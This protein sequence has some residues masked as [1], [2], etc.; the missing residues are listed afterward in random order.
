M[1][2][3]IFQSVTLTYSFNC[4]QALQPIVDKV[5]ELTEKDSP[6]DVT[7]LYLGTPSF[8]AREP[9]LTQTACFRKAGCNVVKLDLSTSDLSS[10]TKQCDD[11]DTNEVENLFDSADALLVSGG[12]TRYALERWRELG[13]DDIIRTNAFREDKPMVLCGGSAGAI[14]W[15]SHAHC[16]RTEDDDDIVDD[17]CDF[18]RLPGMDII[19][20]L[21]VPHHEKSHPNGSL[22]SSDSDEMVLEYKE[23]CI[24]IEE[25]AA[26]ILEGDQVSVV[27]GDGKA[28]CYVKQVSG[29]NILQK[30]PLRE[31]DGQVSF[32]SALADG[33]KKVPLNPTD[34]SP[35]L[36]P[37]TFWDMIHESALIQDTDIILS[38]VE[39][40]DE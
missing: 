19:P 1:C 22:R 39:V 40:V 34:I 9:Y 5:I 16:I 11:F 4:I 6:S 18:I 23:P 15:F 24:G 21:A 35:D 28:K 7:L 36:E 27:S 10:E 37:T 20:G 31:K 12:N 13:V 38:Q 30:F 32:L 29:D 3:L 33:L 25:K 17:E 8:D 14:C 2:V 26:L